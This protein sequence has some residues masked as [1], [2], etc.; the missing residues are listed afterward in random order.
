MGLHMAQPQATGYNFYPEFHMLH[1]EFVH[2]SVSLLYIVAM[3]L[4][5]RVIYL[6]CTVSSG[7]HYVK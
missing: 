4:T 2:G 5:D 3:G 6:G 7:A 1:P